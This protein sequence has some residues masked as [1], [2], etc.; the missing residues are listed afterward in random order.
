MEY[1]VFIS[2]SSK[3]TEVATRIYDSIKSDNVSCWMAPTDIPGG[4]EYE[5]MIVNVIENCKIVVL[6]FS[7]PASVS[8][9]VNSEISIAFSEYKH[10]IPFKID[11]TEIKGKMRVKL[12]DTQIIDA[13]KNLQSKISELVTSIKILLNRSEVE[14]NTKS[15][16]NT[17]T[18]SFIQNL[19]YESACKYMQESDYSEALDIFLRFAVG[20]NIASQEKICEI[21]YKLSMDEANRLLLRK[22]DTSFYNKISAIAVEGKA[23]AN[24]AMHCYNY[25]KN[26][27]EALNYLLKSFQDVEI[28]LAYLRLGIVYDWGLGTKVNISHA[29]KCY[30]KALEL[31]CNYAYSYAAQHYRYV[32]QDLDL[33]LEYAKKGISCKDERSYGQLCS[34]YNDESKYEAHEE[35]LKHMLRENYRSVYYYYGDYYLR[36]W[37]DK[38]IEVYKNKAIK[39]LEIALKSQ[40]YRACGSLAMY[41][42]NQQDYDKSRFY[43]EEGVKKY[44][45]FSYV[46]M[47]YLEIQ[48]NNF[49]AAWDIAME[50]WNL[51]GTGGDILGELYIDRGFRPDGLSVNELVRILDVCSAFDNASC[52]YL[53][54]LYSDIEY[55]LNDS[56]QAKK[57]RRMAADNGDVDDLL[58]YGKSLMD[59]NSDDFDPIKGETYLVNAIQKGSA[60]ASKVLLQYW[61]E[62][63][64]S[65]FLNEKR[66]LV[67][68]KKAY[69]LNDD[70]FELLYPTDVNAENVDSFIDFLITILDSDDDFSKQNKN[71]AKAKL[72]SESYKSNWKLSETLRGDLLKEARNYAFADPIL[73]KDYRAI[74]DVLFPDFNL[75]IPKLEERWFELYYN[76]HEFSDSEADLALRQLKPD[77]LLDDDGNIK[78][79]VKHNM[80]D[81]YQAMDNFWTSYKEIFAELELEYE[82]QVPYLPDSKEDLYFYTGEELIRIKRDMVRGVLSV[83]SHPQ[84]FEMSTVGEYLKADDEEKLN[85]AEKESNVDLQ[86]LLIEHVEVRICVQDALVELAKLKN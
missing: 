17:V 79:G 5:D 46:M 85:I 43:A 64:N 6:V 25:N 42:Y 86:L 54:K 28:G 66:N 71:K 40:E 3:N 35:L 44:D 81:L 82:V 31:G 12:N 63:D 56:A 39:Y 62:A 47:Y 21:M 32:K 4:S 37:Y 80:N 33:A 69:H 84:L 73:F 16:D 18:L 29:E 45:S 78:A 70:F 15:S 74:F 76:T 83:C 23:W 24:F 57:Y 50:R 1:D 9:W 52:N 30:L 68:S 61:K 60:E 7:E 41:Y 48:D 67:L 20:G 51:F 19:D 26:H 65:Y 58:D 75:N 53:V 49:A 59:M 8:R 14:L 55:G 27:S 22:L 38:S 72:L 2:Y 10:I 13:R 34:Y 11:D 77:M 36:R